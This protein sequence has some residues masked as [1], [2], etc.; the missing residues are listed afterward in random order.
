LRDA[1]Q[2]FW[3]APE[4]AEDAAEARRLGGLRRRRE[5]TVSS[6]YDFAGL[7]TIESIRR[8]LEIATIDALGLENSIARSRVLISAAL[9][10][11]K[12][13]EVG[14]LEE[15]LSVLEASIGRSDAVDPDPID[16]ELAA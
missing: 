7:G 10:A 16:A 1:D 3:H 15:R 13:L 5:K 12:L 14:E 2:C 6:A 11:A 8:I 9:A 4:R